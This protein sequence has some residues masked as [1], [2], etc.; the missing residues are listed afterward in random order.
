VTA[1]IC[2]I[3]FLVEFSA[4]CV[5]AA[6]H[7]KAWVDSFHP[8]LSTL[9]VVEADALGLPGEPHDVLSDEGVLDLISKRTAD[10]K[11]FSDQY[12][13]EGVASPTVLGGG[14]A[15][16]QID[17]FAK[18]ENID[19]IMLPRNHQNFLSRLLED[20]LAAKLLER[21]TASVWITEHIDAVPFSP[22]QSILC[23]MH[24]EQ[25]VTL[26][27][28]NHRMLQAVRELAT[29]FQARVA[30]LY[31]INGAAEE[32]SG[33]VRHLQ[34]IAGMESFVAQLHELF[35][36]SAV[37]L[38]RSGDVI[39]AISDTAKLLAAD[40]IVVGRTRPGTIGFGRQAHVLKLDHAVRCPVLSVW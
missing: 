19:L 3:L 40:L 23:A 36:S 16:D 34:A 31:V 7:V 17:S 29:T 8:T 20:S 9:H 39:T 25:D 37:I 28:Q 14:T 2:K 1:K 21:C 15:A 33:S 11:Y 35:G 13:G 18:R 27:A 26:D 22:V 24:F 30:F 5:L 32:S 38:R 10:L 12:F 4:H 6:R